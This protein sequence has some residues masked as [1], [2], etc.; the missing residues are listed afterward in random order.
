MLSKVREAEQKS[1]SAQEGAAK[2]AAI[3][4]EHGEKGM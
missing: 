1:V 3:A 2:A 4:K